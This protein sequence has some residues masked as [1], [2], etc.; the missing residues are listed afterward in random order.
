MTDRE[1]AV[2]VAFDTLDATALQGTFTTVSQA[3]AVSPVLE[4]TARPLQ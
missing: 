3:D 1:S 2:R 4:L